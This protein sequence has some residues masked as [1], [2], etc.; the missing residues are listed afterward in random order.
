MCILPG[1]WFWILKKGC[2]V[3]CYRV[4]WRQPSY[5]FDNFHF[6]L[7][8]SISLHVCV[9]HVSCYKFE[10]VYNVYVFYMCVYMYMFVTH[11][12]FVISVT[13]LTH[14]I[15]SP[16]LPFIAD[17]CCKF[18]A[19]LQREKSISIKTINL[20]LTLTYLQFPCLSLQSLHP[21]KKDGD[22][23][24]LIIKI[25]CHSNCTQFRLA[26]TSTVSEPGMHLSQNITCTL[27]SVVWIQH[28]QKKVLVP[29]AF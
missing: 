26:F 1:N 12:V 25:L 18:C 15:P 4:P 13:C 5:N 6:S 20:P 2:C 21:R 28:M 16:P 10:C 19:R 3:T 24:K 17:W 7:Y 9:L 23:V 14:S 22:P 27:H 11:S 8:V 29:K